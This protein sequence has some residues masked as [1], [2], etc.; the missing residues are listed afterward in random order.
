[1]IKKIPKSKYQCQK[2]KFEFEK[3]M[4]GPVDCPACHYNYLTWENSDDVLKV[5]YRTTKDKTLQQRKENV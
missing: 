2:C 3:E 4:P 5:I 1:L